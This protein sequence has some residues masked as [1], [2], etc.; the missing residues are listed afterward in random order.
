MSE[1]P[2]KETSTFIRLIALI[3][4]YKGLILFSLLHGRFQIFTPPRSIMPKTSSTDRLRRKNP[5]SNS[6][7]VASV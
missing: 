5:N 1:A 7:L 6:I 3:L 2:K 4:P